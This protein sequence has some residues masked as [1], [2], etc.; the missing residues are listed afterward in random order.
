M[1][2][3]MSNAPSVSILVFDSSVLSCFAR[4][5]RLDSLDALTAGR[6]RVMTPAVIEE[7][8]QGTQEHPR[9][10]KVQ[11]IEWIETV[12]V[13]G[14]DEL[15]AFSEYLRFLGGGPRNVGEAATLAWAEVHCA[16]A[17]LD[18]QTAVQLGR[19]RGVTVKRTLSLIATGVERGLL[20]DYEAVALVEDLI[21]GGA[22]FPCDGR[23]FI[24]WCRAKGLLR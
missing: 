2:A 12:R 20:S 3:A 19:Q 15:V 5:G 23:E 10:A 18:D 6:R 17:V 7:L 8:A 11:Q 13:D 4:A 24:T 16:V 14:L 1:G 21:G 9:L 22:R